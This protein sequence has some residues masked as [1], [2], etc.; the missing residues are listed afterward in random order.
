MSNTFT[1]SFVVPMLC[2]ALLLIIGTIVFGWLKKLQR[3]RF[4]QW[5]F[6]DYVSVGHAK[7]LYTKYI[8]RK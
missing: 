2:V 6:L 3:T 5:T 7:H 4:P 1:V 8:L